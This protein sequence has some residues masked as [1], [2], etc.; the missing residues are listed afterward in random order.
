MSEGFKG[1][2]APE[3]FNE[4]KRYALFQAQQL[5]SL[6]DAELR[7]MHQMSSTS[8]R[9]FVQGQIGDCVI[10]DG[11]KIVAATDSTNNFSILGGNGTVEDPGVLFLKGY[12]LFLRDPID[13]KDQTNAGFITDD[14]YTETPLPSLTTPTGTVSDIYGIIGDSTK[15]IT[16]GADGTALKT[17]DSGRSFVPK[18][19]GSSYT[20]SSVCLGGSNVYAAGLSGNILKSTD[21]GETFFG[22]D[23]EPYNLYGISFKDSLYGYKIGRAHV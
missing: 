16:V 13:Y 8:L 15:F 4:E 7:D 6:T 10:D 14:S 3:L 12:R 18:T 2:Y 21:G 1:N 11:F 17:I 9:R 5:A 22:I 20:I 23:I 19:S